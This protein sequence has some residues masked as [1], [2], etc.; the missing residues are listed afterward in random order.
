MFEQQ[1]SPKEV[2]EF[3]LEQ[4][5]S[6]INTPYQVFAIWFQYKVYRRDLSSAC[7]AGIEY[8]ARNKN[9]LEQW[10]YDEFIELLVFHCLTELGEYKRALRFLKRNTYLSQSKKTKYIKELQRLIRGEDGSTETASPSSSSKGKKSEHSKG[11]DAGGIESK[12]GGVTSTA[13]GTGSFG[14]IGKDIFESKKH[15]LFQKEKQG[16]GRPALTRWE[17][18]MLLLRKLLKRLK[19]VA[20]VAF[21]LIFVGILLLL[22]RNAVSSVRFDRLK[23]EAKR[24]L[25]LFFA[26]DPL[27]R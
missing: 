27:S 14:N 13:S 18:V 4:Y 10:Q 17:R 2:D 15:A 7:S 8:L 11:V 24:F 25:S 26:L 5:E 16:Q 12:K 1:K 22:M 3:V 20:P 21:A 23:L 9:S 6:F 19:E